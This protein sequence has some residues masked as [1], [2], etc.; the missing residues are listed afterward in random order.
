[1]TIPN[2]PVPRVGVAVIVKKGK[3]VLLGKRKGSHGAGCWSFPGGHLEFKETVEECAI[4]ELLEETGLK[5]HSC[6]SG[7]WTNDVM[8]EKHYVT[9][10]MIVDAF[11]G[12]PQLMEPT[13]CEGWE[14]FSWDHLPTPL[15]Y[16]IRSLLKTGTFP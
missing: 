4:R 15:F 3:T 9:L 16:P 5:A 1:M 12:Q 10:F 13:K 11:D 6:H 14:W 7:P 8:E 2:K